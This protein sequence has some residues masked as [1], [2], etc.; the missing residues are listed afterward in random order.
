MKIWPFLVSR[1]RE[2]DYGTVVIPDFIQCSENKTVLDFFT[3]GEASGKSTVYL[4]QLDCHELGSLSL[5]Y[6]IS[7]AS[8]TDIGY[9]NTDLLQDC[10]HR[11]IQIVRGGVAREQLTRQS[12]CERLL[13]R[14]ESMLGKAFEKF[15]FDSSVAGRISTGFEW[16]SSLGAEDLSS[17]LYG[18]AVDIIELGRAS[19]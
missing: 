16:S 11:P 3:S 1:N 5:F 18:R 8:C 10:F 9:K 4:R 19:C 7:Y 14:T 12:I 15:W 6:R 17:G 13:K 2:I